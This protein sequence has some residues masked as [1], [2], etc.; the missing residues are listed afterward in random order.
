MA[1]VGTVKNQYIVTAMRFSFSIRER[2]YIVAMI[3]NAT[4][5]RPIMVVM[6]YELGK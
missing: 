2:R 4:S 6:A 1:P 3:L 5:S